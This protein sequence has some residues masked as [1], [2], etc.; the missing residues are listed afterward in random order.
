LLSWRPQR[1]LRVCLDRLAALTR[2]CLAE[3]TACAGQNFLG[4]LAARL[5]D[6]LRDL[7]LLRQRLR[8]VHEVLVCPPGLEPDS[9]IGEENAEVF[10]ETSSS[11]HDSSS[12]RPTPMTS[13]ASFR[14]SSPTSAPARV[15]LPVVATDLD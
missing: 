4:A 3:D 6:R 15:V 10:A 7:S 5:R 12:L 13:L 1:Q 9:G 14:Q 2:Q 11:T 8:H